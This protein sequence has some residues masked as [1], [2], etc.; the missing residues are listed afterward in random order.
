MATLTTQSIVNTGLAPTYQ[1]AAGGGDKVRPGT[2]VFLHV[3]NDGGGSVTVTV[4]DVLSQEPSGAAAFDP[5]LEVVIEPA[6]ERMIGPIVETRFR[7][8]DGLAAI[9]YSGVSSVTVAALRV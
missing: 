4:D 1:A 5:N 8:S 6:G 7:G 9:T 2:R 3:K